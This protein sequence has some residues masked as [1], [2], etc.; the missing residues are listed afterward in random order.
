MHLFMSLQLQI[1][2]KVRSC[3]CFCWGSAWHGSRELETAYWLKT[4]QSLGSLELTLP[5]GRPRQLPSV[6]AGWGN[7]HI[8]RS[9]LVACLQ[10]E[11]K[12][13]P[14]QWPEGQILIYMLSNLFFL[15]IR[16]LWGRILNQAGKSERKLSILPSHDKQEVS[17]WLSL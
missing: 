12:L 4:P 15:I 6:W 7:W 17:H 9:L 16:N 14:V 3:F 2:C 10:E 11:N 1:G 5:L 13:I 8:K